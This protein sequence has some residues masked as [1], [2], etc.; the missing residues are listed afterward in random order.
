MSNLLSTARDTQLYLICKLATYDIGLRIT[1]HNIV[2]IAD[3]VAY[4]NSFLCYIVH[5]INDDF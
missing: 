4:D 3:L 5:F 2:V 1:V